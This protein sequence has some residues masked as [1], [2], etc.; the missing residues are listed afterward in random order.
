MTGSRGVAGE[1]AALVI[2]LLIHM[3]NPGIFRGRSTDVP[4][5]ATVGVFEQLW[6][7]RPQYV[8]KKWRLCAP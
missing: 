1:D 7:I 3:G 6:N 5:L 8:R 4:A 2:P